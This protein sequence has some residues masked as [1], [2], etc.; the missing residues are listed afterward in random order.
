MKR[1]T[2][3]G[4][5]YSIYFFNNTSLYLLLYAHMNSERDIYCFDKLQYYGTTY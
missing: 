5:K 3:K 2:R 1:K 4:N